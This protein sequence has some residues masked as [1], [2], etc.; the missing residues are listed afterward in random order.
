M[1]SQTKP[2]QEFQKINAIRNIY[3]RG[4][5]T[6][7]GNVEQLWADY[8]NFEK[9]VN[10]NLADKLVSERQ[11]DYQTAR[12]TVKQLELQQRGLHVRI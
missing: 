8:V 3:H 5:V 10:S 9:G 7:I 6:P 12:R 11:R 4:V 1:R 2:Q